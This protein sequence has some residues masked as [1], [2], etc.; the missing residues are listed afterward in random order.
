MA[1][2]FESCLLQCRALRIL[3][4]QNHFGCTRCKE[5]HDFYWLLYFI[6]AKNDTFQCLVLERAV[7]SLWQRCYQLGWALH[8]THLLGVGSQWGIVLDT[9]S[10]TPNGWLELS[11]R[12]WNMQRTVWTLTFV[13]ASWWSATVAGE[14]A[15]GGSTCIR[16]T[17]WPR[18]PHQQHVL[19]VT[20]T[21]LHGKLPLQNQEGNKGKCQWINEQKCKVFLPKC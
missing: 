11:E 5:W 20:I 10:L 21:A 2:H 1:I 7:F 16:G 13:T 15:A 12:G 14:E 4:C 18:H 19:T 9:A 6:N 17:T 8:Q 3:S